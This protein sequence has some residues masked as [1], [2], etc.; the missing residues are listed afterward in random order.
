MVVDHLKAKYENEDIGVACIYLDHN[1]ASFQ[2]PSKLL[3]GLWRQLVDRDRD[4]GPVAKELFQQHRIR[5]TIPSLGEV[6]GLLDSALT[7]FSKVFL[8]VDGLDECP[9]HE[10]HIL[11]QPLAD[12]NINLNLMV[13]SQPHISPESFSFADL[14]TLDIHAMPE[15]IRK[16]V[17]TQ[18]KFSTQLSQ[19]IR[20]QPSLKEEI[21]SK[22]TENA[23]G[24]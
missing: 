23:G 7:E 13:T 18:I 12:R 24:M 17:D 19:A 16:Y 3:A 2:K 22:I 5:G 21:L 20:K 14:E 15:D 4:V 10:R 6:L 1:K 11:L 9:E 8:V